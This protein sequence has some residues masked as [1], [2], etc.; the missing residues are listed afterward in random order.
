MKKS[1]NFNRRL[2]I[3]LLRLRGSGLFKISRRCWKLKIRTCRIR[4]GHHPKVSRK[5]SK[6]TKIECL[7]NPSLLSFIKINIKVVMKITMSNR[8]NKSLNNFNTKICQYNPLKI[9]NPLL[10]SKFKIIKMK[11]LWRWN[12]LTWNFHNK[13]RKLSQGS[14][15]CINRWMNLTGRGRRWR[16]INSK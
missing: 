15:K 2:I 7:T 9:S 11:R 10:Q 13:Q 6:K 3:L 8:Q 16:I 12:N 4:L 1:R 14:L 5:N